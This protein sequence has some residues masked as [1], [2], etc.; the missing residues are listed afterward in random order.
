MKKIISIIIMIVILTAVPLY[1]C[2][3]EPKIQ[4]TKYSDT[5]FDAFDTVI[6][7]VAYTK[8]EEEFKYYYEKIKNRFQELHREYDIYNNYEGLKNIK[9]IND[10]AGIKPVYVSKD[11]IDLILFS[12]EWDKRSGGATNIALGAVL[13]I[14]HDYREVG[15]NDPENAKLPPMKDLMD[16][17]KHTDI[18]KVIVD[19]EKG[20]VYLEDK[21]MSL[22]VGAVAKGYATEIVAREIMDEGLTSGII[23]A[24]GN[25]RTIGKPLDG[26]RNS[27]G[28]GI[29]DPSKSVFSNEDNTLDT[30]FVK[31]MSIV[32]SGVYE[33]YYVVGDKEYHHLID[34]RTLMPGE[35]Y[36]AVT[37]V[38][39]NS[40]DADA[41]STA[42]FLLPFEKSKALVESLEGVEALWVMP[43]GSVE[44][45]SGMG[46][47]MLSHG[48]TGTG[49]N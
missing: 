25:V 40:G 18:D 29:Q 21:R 46:K 43:D 23:N 9:T 35:Y 10:N 31:D 28:I 38:T 5:F 24:G 34:P 17:A 27:W 15:R 6:R 14:W 30:L 44:I 11:I 47:I 48:A 49:K 13:S 19:T 42:V 16:A 7:V 3:K 36:K 1:G 2:K 37:I 45:S 33:R 20:T 26:E 4:Y 22:D 41:L 39:Q 32:S 12:K 8:N